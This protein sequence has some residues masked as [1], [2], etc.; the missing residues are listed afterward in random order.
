VE[1]KLFDWES[2]DQQDVACLSFNE[3][4]LKVRVGKFEAGTKF[5]F[6]FV[7]YDEGYLQLGNNLGN[8]HDGKPLQETFDFKLQLSVV[9]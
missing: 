6:A 9:E 1:C 5:D 7:N 2:W 4:V 3:V 8:D